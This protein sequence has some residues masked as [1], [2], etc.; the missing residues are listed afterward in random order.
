MAPL[1]ICIDKNKEK[2]NRFLEDMTH[3]ENLEQH[4]N[5]CLIG[6]LSKSLNTHLSFFSA[7]LDRYI[8]LG[9]TDENSIN[10]SFNE[11]YFIHE[12]LIAHKTELVYK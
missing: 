10:I 12:L 3:V 2:L 1:N 9:R 8:A 6:P 4:L 5:V 7:Q 11:M